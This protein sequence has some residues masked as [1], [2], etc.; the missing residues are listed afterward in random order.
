MQSIKDRL[1]AW[2]KKP[3]KHLVWRQRLATADARVFPD[4]I[5]I[6]AQKAGTTSLHAWL[7]QH[8]QILPPLE[9]EVHYFDGGIRAGSD[10]F[11]R[12]PDWYRAHFPRRQTATGSISFETTPMYLF[13]PLAA[14]RIKSLL[15]AVKLVALLRNP[16]ERA[17]SHYFHAVRNGGETLA[18]DAAFAAEAQRL[19]PAL[20]AG[21]YAAP[22]FVR[23]SYQAR[24]RYAEQLRRYFDCFAREQILVLDSEGL[25][26]APD[27]Y[28]Q[29]IYEFAGVDSGF[30]PPDLRPRNVSAS[31]QPVDDA[32]YAALNEYFRPHNRELF[33]LLG[34]SFDW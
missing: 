5:V 8:P 18:A 3:L 27:E 6:G 20:A 29:R 2:V 32:V 23:H 17:V 15:P 14:A 16:A 13:H 30:T 26:A 11:A 25:F 7:A 34:E 10:N 24:G 1:P 19:A 12:G 33:G 22:E 31:R 9:K 4:L 28:L 21:D